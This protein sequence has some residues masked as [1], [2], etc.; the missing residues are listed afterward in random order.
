MADV[1]LTDAEYLEFAHRLVD[2]L[3]EYGFIAEDE[4]EIELDKIL[5][6]NRAKPFELMN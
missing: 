2:L 3:V 6:K 4:V 5:A 1:L